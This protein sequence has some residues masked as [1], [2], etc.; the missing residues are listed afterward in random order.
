MKTSYCKS[1]D[2]YEVKLCVRKIKI[3]YVGDF[4]YPFCCDITTQ[5]D[6]FFRC[7]VLFS[8]IAQFV[9]AQENDVLS[10]KLKVVYEKS[11]VMGVS[12]CKNLTRSWVNIGTQKI[13]LNRGTFF[14]ANI[15]LEQCFVLSS[16]NND[17]S[18]N[19]YYWFLTQASN[20]FVCFF[21]ED[22]FTSHLLGAQK[23]DIIKL[24]VGDWNDF[25]QINVLQF[26]EN[27]SRVILSINQAVHEL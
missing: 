2:E 27:K 17:H 15:T 4:N 10:L 18:P 19:L 9:L 22:R 23:G 5:D 25:D 7:A 16:P 13:L 8:D 6:V 24:R 14:E 26:F 11:W 1:G 21:A 12:E 20:E 3:E